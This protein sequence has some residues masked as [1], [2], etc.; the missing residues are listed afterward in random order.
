M[1]TS[2][3]VGK[4]ELVPTR[5]ITIRGAKRQWTLKNNPHIT[6]DIAEFSSTFWKVQLCREVQDARSEGV[7]VGIACVML[8]ELALSLEP[9][10]AHFKRE[11]ARLDRAIRRPSG[12]MA[13]VTSSA[14][15]RR[16]PP[17]SALTAVRRQHH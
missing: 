7:A 1:S 6:L 3:K 2:I 13:A 15:A 11:Q 12:E 17:K 16:G 4:L 8:H 9:T 5:N 10:I 14:P